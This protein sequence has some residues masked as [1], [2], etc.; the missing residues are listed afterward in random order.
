MLR[1]NHPDDSDLCKIEFRPIEC[2]FWVL[3]KNI[4]AYVAPSEKSRHYTFLFF[5]KKMCRLSELSSIYE[6]FICVY[7]MRI[8]YLWIQFSLEILCLDSNDIKLCNF[9]SF[10]VLEGTCLFKKDKGNVNPLPL[11]PLPNHLVQ[12]QK[13]YVPWHFFL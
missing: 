10:G 2:R 9:D 1:I 8:W 4:I 5:Q 12:K 3:Y 7:C 11:L 13:S 6:I